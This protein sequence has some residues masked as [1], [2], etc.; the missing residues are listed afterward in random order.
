M[1]LEILA[2]GE[3]ALTLWALKHKL[4]YILRELDNSPNPLLCQAFFR[5]SFGRRGGKNSSQFGEFDFIL[6]T[7]N[8][9]YLGESKWENS[10]EKIVDGKI[11]L[12]EEQ[13]LRHKLF[14]FYITEWAF[15]SY[16]N[17]EWKQFSSDAK[18]KLI[19][20]D[21]E[22]PIATENSL[23]AENLQT[24]LKLIKEYYK[25]TGQP[26]IKN[27]LLYFHRNLD[28]EQLPQKAGKD[29]DVV[30]IDYSEEL[31]GNYIKL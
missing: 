24:T 12:R 7:E 14:K 27:V 16:E 15:G 13:L 22:K 3:D 10:S 4:E 18:S 31:T 11:E 9:I 1:E 6:L 19:Q 20:E 21:I 28:N 2:Y 8:C 30:L 29:F 25:N 17:N 5:P 26:E 23:L